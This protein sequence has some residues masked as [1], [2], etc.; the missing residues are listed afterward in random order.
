M[1]LDRV[2]EALQKCPVSQDGTVWALRIVPWHNGPAFWWNN[3]DGS[4]IVGESTFN[5]TNAAVKTW[6][7][8]ISRR[9]LHVSALSVR[10]CVVH[11]P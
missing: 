8:E 10:Q 11:T 7:E 5:A 9:T 6:V 3:E 1:N 2:R 4:P